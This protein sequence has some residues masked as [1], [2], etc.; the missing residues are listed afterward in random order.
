MRDARYLASCGRRV[1]ASDYTPALANDSRLASG[2]PLFEFRVL[3]AF[4]TGLAD[5]SCD[6]TY[7]NGLWVL[8]QSNGEL[9]RLAREQARITRRY[10]VAT[11][12]SAH[13]EGLKAS[14][15]SRAADDPLY[16][17]RF[18]TRDELLELLRPYGPTTILPFRGPWDRQL[19]E[20]W[21]LGRL[22]CRARR[23]VYRRICPRTPLS[24]WERIMAVTKV[25]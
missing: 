10:M 23:L 9:H 16:D 7:H 15:A 8:F 5:K 3:D 18:F 21:R 1:I 22:P 13:N 19:I 25:G 17:I 20:G 6:V 11:V 14:F 12:H 2:N 4:A 24:R